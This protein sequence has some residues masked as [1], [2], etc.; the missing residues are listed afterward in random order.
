MSKLVEKLKHSVFE[1]ESPGS[2]HKP[3][4]N[5]IHTPAPYLSN[6]T[7]PEAAYVDSELYK[8]LLEKT[9]FS[10]TI[11]GQL[12]QKCL[13]TFSEFDETT[14]TKAALAMA[15]SQETDIPLKLRNTFSALLT[16][17]QQENTKF[18]NS[19]RSGQT[20]LEGQKK[21]L[22]Q[23]QAQVNQLTTSIQANELKLNSATSDFQAAFDRRK[24]ELEQ[25]AAHYNTLL[26][27][28]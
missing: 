26:E 27:A 10:G 5:V 7:P 12:L 8:T 3:S 13:A 2:P 19:L 20:E 9:N 28:K 1:E 11:L 4:T 23:L 6:P 16:A 17:L 18:Q 21:M 14:K 22:V 25:E 15:K 24:Q